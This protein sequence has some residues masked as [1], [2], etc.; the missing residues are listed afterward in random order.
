MERGHDLSAYGQQ[1][2]LPAGGILPGVDAA[3]DCCAAAIDDE[4]D[5]FQVQV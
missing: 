1:E 5:I 2:L 4:G 3:G